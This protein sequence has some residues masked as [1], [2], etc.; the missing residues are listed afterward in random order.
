M[1]RAKKSSRWAGKA[2]KPICC[3]SCER[4][5]V[6]LFVVTGEFIVSLQMVWLYIN[7][8]RLRASFATRLDTDSWECCLLRP[9]LLAC[10]LFHSRYCR[11][12]TCLHRGVV[13]GCSAVATEDFMASVGC[14]NRAHRRFR[15]GSCPVRGAGASA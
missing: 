11:K 9:Y 12:R 1:A 3:R 4:L 14:T 10:I 8:L 15:I 6:G 7:G 13:R 5:F 2:R